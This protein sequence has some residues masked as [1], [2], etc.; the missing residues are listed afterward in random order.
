MFVA[1]KLLR[2]VSAGPA[3]SMQRDD[4]CSLDC[5]ELID[6][7]RRTAEHGQRRRGRGR[8]SYC[9]SCIG[10]MAL[11]LIVTVNAHDTMFVR[12]ILVFVADGALKL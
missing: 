1:V 10:R 8:R 5:R 4:R 9:C 2:D 3:N 12:G 6:A 11:L 7:T